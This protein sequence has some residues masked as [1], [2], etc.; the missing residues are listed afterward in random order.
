MSIEIVTV[1]IV[2][3]IKESN[4]EEM[5]AMPLVR[6]AAMKKRWLHLMA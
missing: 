5:K 6:D 4:H 3:G 1:G 2:T